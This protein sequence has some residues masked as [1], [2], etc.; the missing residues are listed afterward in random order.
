MR[1][2]ER[3]FVRGLASFLRGD[4]DLL[5]VLLGPR[6]VGKTTT[7]LDWFL[8]K[9]PNQYIYINADE[10]LV[11]S[12]DQLVEV[13]QEAIRQKKILILDEIH[14]VPQWDRTLKGLWDR[15]HREKRG[16]K[17][18]V[19]GSSSLEVQAGLQESLAGRFRLTYVPHWSFT[20]SSNHFGL[21]LDQYLNFGGYPGS[22]R[23]LKDAR[24]WRSFVRD[25]I[26]HAVLERD[27]LAN[28]TVKN[29]ALFRQ[30][31]ELLAT[32]PGQEISFTKL[33]GNL[34]SKGN[35][36]VV[37]HYIKLFEGAYFFKALQK[38]SK[39]GIRKRLSAPKILPLAPAVAVGGSGVGA[40]DESRGR[41]FESVV[42]ATLMR[43]T[44]E[45]T[46]WREGNAEVDFIA[47]AGKRTFAIEVKSGAKP[48]LR[49][50]GFDLLQKQYPKIVPVFITEQNFASFDAD[51]L[52]FL[53]AI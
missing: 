49:R 13:W 33:L 37:Q 44:E 2:L 24:I 20:E 45:L 27:I 16:M 23:Y 4:E 21:T 11:P 12:P 6:Q 31:F 29:P 3:A 26:L 43:S 50:V 32:L 28:H 52:Q 42:G 46:Y 48:K 15:Q 8:R 41:I 34:Q 5:Q 30:A 25:S 36:E 1:V 51:P 18:V 14:R 53:G 40:L 10:W 35:V 19:L 22:Y 38:Y 39:N 7:T 47:G 17:I 9:Y